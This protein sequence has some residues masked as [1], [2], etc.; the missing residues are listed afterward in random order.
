MLPAHPFTASNRVQ[1][2]VQTYDSISD[3]RMLLLLLHLPKSTKRGHEDE[4]G[5]RAVD[6]VETGFDK[7][8]QNGVK[9]RKHKNRNCVEQNQY[10]AASGLESRQTQ[11]Y[12]V[13]LM[14]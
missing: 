11:V 9:T 5:E 14:H 10:A 3:I 1:S 6:K 2:T 4:G 12:T 8:T 7:N 13:S